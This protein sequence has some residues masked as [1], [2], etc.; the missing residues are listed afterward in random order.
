MGVIPS[1]FVSCFLLGILATT[2]NGQL[3]TGQGIL[4]TAQGGNLGSS[5]LTGVPNLN[6]ALASILGPILGGNSTNGGVTIIGSLSKI[7]SGLQEVSLGT[8]LQNILSGNLSSLQHIL[9]PVVELLL[10]LPIVGPLIMLLSQVL[11][12]PLTLVASIVALLLEIL[13]VLLNITRTTSG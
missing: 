8:L 9:G 6:D 2:G 11:N 5:S 7:L 13:M 12:I 4:P 1:L 3:T 10:S